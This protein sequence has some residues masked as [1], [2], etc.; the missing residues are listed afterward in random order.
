L[1]VGIA[2]ARI[3]TPAEIEVALLRPQPEEEALMIAVA[4]PK[5]LDPQ[6]HDL[7]LRIEK[8]RQN[9]GNHRMSELLR[10]AE[11]AMGICVKRLENARHPSQRVDWD[12]P[13]W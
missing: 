4:P 1:L 10:L 7:H 12:A 5:P 3:L 8:A 11:E 9:G 6:L 13:W 2:V